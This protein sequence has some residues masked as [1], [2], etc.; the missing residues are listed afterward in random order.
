[1]G[2]WTSSRNSLHIKLVP[3]KVPKAVF[4][5]FKNKEKEKRKRK[6]GQEEEVEW[7]KKRRR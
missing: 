3:N 6:R 1:M 2:Q 7:G 4:I 5:H